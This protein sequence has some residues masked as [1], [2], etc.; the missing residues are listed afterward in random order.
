MYVQQRMMIC[1]RIFSGAE[2]TVTARRLVN[3]EGKGRL[4]FDTIRK[5]TTTYRYTILIII[6]KYY[7]SK[8]K[9]KNLTIARL[10]FVNY[11]TR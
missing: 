3:K 1:G 2:Y 10:S 5:S 7:A 8:L 6:T 11:L 4:Y 9:T